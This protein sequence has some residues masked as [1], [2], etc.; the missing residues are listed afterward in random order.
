M[1]ENIKS[2]RKELKRSLCMQ[3]KYGITEKYKRKKINTMVK[4]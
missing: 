4:R 1:A 3:N 2:V